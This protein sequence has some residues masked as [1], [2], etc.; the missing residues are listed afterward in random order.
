[1]YGPDGLNFVQTMIN[2]ARAGKPLRVVND[3]IGSPTYTRDLA[4]A[5]LNLIDAGATSIYHVTNSGQTTWFDFTKAILEEFNLKTELS[6]ISSA[7]W[8][9]LHP[10]SAIRPAYSVLDTSKYTQ[11]TGKTMRHWREALHDY[12]IALESETI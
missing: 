1:L 8:K 5:T 10:D 9:K 6:P 7:D 2:A 11:T 3:Q 4:E 12:R